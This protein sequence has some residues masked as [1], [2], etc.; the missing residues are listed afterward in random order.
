MFNR[1]RL[2]NAAFL[3]N[4]GYGYYIFHDVDIFPV[5]GT[6]KTEPEHFGYHGMPNYFPIDQARIILKPAQKVA[7][8]IFGVSNQVYQEVNGHSNSYWGWGYE[9]REF[10]VRLRRNGIRIDDQGKRAHRNYGKK[11]FKW[12]DHG[13]GWVRGFERNEEVF[14]RIMKH[15]RESFKQDG[16]NSTLY[17][18]EQVTDQPGYKQIDLWIYTAPPHDFG[19]FD[20][21]LKC[22]YLNAV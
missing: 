3:E 21:N 2:V 17:R 1:G 9:D 10:F 11:W 13:S 14:N 15:P 6:P 5:R 18:V 7:G 22:I 12:L 8:C 16:L 20:C 19:K 4:M